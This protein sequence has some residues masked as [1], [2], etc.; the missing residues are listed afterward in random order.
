MVDGGQI[1]QTKEQKLRASQ[2]G[3]TLEQF[4]GDPSGKDAFTLQKKASDMCIEAG[5]RTIFANEI[6]EVVTSKRPNLEINIKL[7]GDD[8]P[9][10]EL[11]RYTS[12]NIAKLQDIIN[13]KEFEFLRN[14]GV[15][16]KKF[17]EGFNELSDRIFKE[18]FIFSPSELVSSADINRY[19]SDLLNYRNGKISID[20][21][22]KQVG[23]NEFERNVEKKL[24]EIN[25][26]LESH[27]V[28]KLYDEINAG[29]K[30]P[31][32]LSVKVIS[33]KV[34]EYHGL[35]EQKVD[36]QKLSYM[37][38]EF[39]SDR[40]VPDPK[41]WA[42]LYQIYEKE[43]ATSKHNKKDIKITPPTFKVPESPTVLLFNR[44]ANKIGVELV[45]TGPKT[46]ESFK[47]KVEARAKEKG[48]PIDVS[49]IMDLSRFT[50]TVT[51]LSG[52][53][54]LM[55]QVQKV[56]GGKN[57][58]YE[59]WGF[60]KSF[61]PSAKVNA[62]VGLSDK[63][64]PSK[65]FKNRMVEIKFTHK[66]LLAA[67]KPADKIYKPRRKMKIKDEAAAVL[68]VS[69]ESDV[70]TRDIYND[71]KL[72]FENKKLQEVGGKFNMTLKMPDYEDFKKQNIFE[73]IYNNITNLERLCFI[74]GISKA[75]QTIGNRDRAFKDYLFVEMA[76]QSGLGEEVEKAI[77][78]NGKT[79]KVPEQKK[80]KFKPED[81]KMF[82]KAYSE[83]ERFMG[84]I[85]FYQSVISEARGKGSRSEQPDPA[86][87]EVNKVRVVSKLVN[88]IS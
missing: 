5:F 75:S 72:I 12:D 26:K 3:L 74:D 44:L 6:W 77:N 18:K 84:M 13:S 1:K 50:F 70:V 31:S 33:D 40:T 22:T 41:D 68:D 35:L 64:A 25:D 78:S 27:S 29:K 23:W 87:V 46:F 67:K 55:N 47:R 69:K 76:K 28:R 73:S 66:D 32:A 86:M 37:V 17:R 49:E 8:N 58:L 80:Y 54:F 51:T 82:A 43:F 20:G 7:N 45:D 65:H 19:N 88:M 60:T 30:D 62:Q 59:H 34:N 61:C 42:N 39:R 56:F 63:E 11:F 4:Y 81:F 2:S 85:K 38:D 36:W 57:C 24:K 21:K 53:K 16:P 48:G 52:T 9:F 71:I 14:D 10:K 79:C 15:D 83:D